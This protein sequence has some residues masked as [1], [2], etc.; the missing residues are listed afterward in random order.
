MNNT[1]LLTKMNTIDERKCKQLVVSEVYGSKNK[2]LVNRCEICKKLHFT[3]KFMQ[4]KG[5]I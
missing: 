1:E 4:K 2:K 3:K 5:W